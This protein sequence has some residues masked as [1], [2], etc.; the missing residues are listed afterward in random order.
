M[1]A[2]PGDAWPEQ[3]GG[4]QSRLEWCIWLPLNVLPMQWFEMRSS[5]D[6]GMCKMDM[7]KI[8]YVTMRSKSALCKD[9][10]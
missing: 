2:S 7:S 6:S 5:C 4:G 3:V 9:R 1:L 8:R 10:F